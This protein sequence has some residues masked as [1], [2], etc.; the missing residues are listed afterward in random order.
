MVETLVGR[1]RELERLLTFA[2]TAT[3][4]GGGLLFQGPPGIGKSFTLAAFCGQAQTHGFQ[5]LQVSG[6]QSEARLAFAGLHQLLRPL[7]HRADELPPRQR[8]AL[9]SGFGMTETVAPDPYLI[10]LAGLELLTLTSARNPVLAIVDDAQWLDQ[11]SAEALAFVLRRLGDDHVAFVIATRDGYRTPLSVLE[12]PVIELG[13][14]DEDHSA[15]LLDARAPHLDGRLRSR[16][17]TQAGGNPLALLELAAA[18]HQP[19]TLQTSGVN[20]LPM[21]DRLERAFTS[22]YVDLSDPLR[23]LLLLAA[24]SDTSDTSE[25]VSAGQILLKEDLIDADIWNPAVHAG[26]VT[27][28]AQRIQFRHPLVRSAIYQRATTALRASAH[29]AL[30][31]ILADQPDRRVWHR[32]AATLRPDEEVARE[33]EDAADRAEARGGRLVTLEALERSALLTPNPGRRAERFLRSAELAQELGDPLAATRLRDQIEADS[34]DPRSSGR[35]RLLS[36]LLG[37]SATGSADVT[38][39]ILE[40]IDLADQMSAQ[41]D[42]DLAL[43]F[44]HLAAIQTWV[45]DVG[46]GL[47]SMALATA[48]RVTPSANDPL[49]LSIY[50]L[51]DPEGHNMILI[52]RAESI[53]PHD[54][55]ARTAHLVGAALN[56]AGAFGVS[57][58]FL[59]SAA[60]KY[61]AE[62]RL[63]Q[64]V[65]VLAQQAWSAFPSLDWLVATPSADESIRLAQETG[66]PLWQASA[67]IVQAVLAGVRGDFTFAESQIAAAEAIALPMGANAILCGIQLTRGLTAVGAGRYDEAFEQLQRLFDPRDPSYHHFQSAWALGDLAEAALHT[68]SIEAARAQLET[69]ELHAHMGESTWT[70]VSL[71]YAKT[72]LADG[73]AEAMFRAALSADLSMWP[74]YRARLLLNYGFWLRR[75]RRAADSRAPLRSAREA[76]DALGARAFAEQARTELRAAGER[77]HGPETRAWRELSPQELHIAQLAA[78]GLSNREI[79][80]R[81]YLSHRT[82]AS[83]LYRVYPKLDITSRVQLQAA[84]NQWP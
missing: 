37:P 38:A 49:L 59:A 34:L 62:G 74:L 32:A 50:S 22:R 11:P 25:V 52:N 20:E 46:Q 75:Q 44:A 2:Q 45:T 1:E 78:E 73:D 54:T 53:V 3:R 65:E 30:A 67:L 13:P 66:Q 70:Q 15:T 12:L 10:A 60:T 41:G 84:L 63:N 36:E 5:Q 27:V 6:V 58:P 4:R 26:L 64:L 29:G 47:R 48:E 55:D 51:T 7:L 42:S 83:H 33:I 14:L 72:L 61:R 8:E 23:M 40:L 68:D 69:V 56:L 28:G 21:T 24:A 31:Q 82:V 17:L 16:V 79:G 39:K 80:A 19:G 9:L 71:L 81:L 35:L 18:P 77:S 57:A 43:R 76:F